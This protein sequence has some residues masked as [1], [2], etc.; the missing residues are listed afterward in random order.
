MN[1]I[2]KFDEDDRKE[3]MRIAEQYG[4][5]SFVVNKYPEW[6]INGWRNEIL[7]ILNNIGIEIECANALYITN[8][9]EYYNRRMHWNNALG[10][11]LALKDKLHEVISCINVK[12]GAYVA[13][14]ELITKELKLLKAVRK[15]D[16]RLLPKINNQLPY[17]NNG[18][19]YNNYPPMPFVP[20]YYENNNSIG[21]MREMVVMCKIVDNSMPRQVAAAA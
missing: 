15:S 17:Y 18:F 13:A 5:E 11:C 10:Y 9:H 6:L 3:F 19:V 16:N 8:I 12:I 21:P 14:F 4:V 1:E 2:Y 20:N 7:M